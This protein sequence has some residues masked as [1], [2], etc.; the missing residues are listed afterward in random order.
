MA[1]TPAVLLPLTLPGLL[2]HMLTTQSPT[3]ITTLVVCSSRDAFLHALVHAAQRQEAED[4]GSLERLLTP[5]LHNLFTAKDVR[6]AFC[7]SLQVLLAN[8]SAMKVTASSAVSGD[9]RRPRMVLVNPLAL[10]ASTPAYSA[11]GLSRTFAAAVDTASK[12]G[13]ELIMVECLGMRREVHLQDEE[14]DQDAAM[15]HVEAEED[16]PS[17]VEDDPW[18]QDLSILN[19][20]APRFG[21]GS[22]ERAWAGRTVKAKTVAGRW[23]RFQHLAGAQGSQRPE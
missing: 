7:P 6:L 20:S 17:A 4:A 13:A 1:L 11:Q 22:G 21:S 18:D 10:H 8:L 9:E 23:F 14:N 19:V 16:L 15:G 5:T 2:Q 12:L 3:T